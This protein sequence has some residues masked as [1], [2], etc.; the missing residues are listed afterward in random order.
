MSGISINCKVLLS[1]K[2]RNLLSGGNCTVVLTTD[3][4]ING[5]GLGRLSLSSENLEEL[6]ID[7]LKMGET[8]IGIE[9]VDVVDEMPSNKAVANIFSTAVEKED[10]KT[11]TVIKKVAVINPPERGEESTAMKEKTET[12]QE[13]EALNN[14]ECVD[15]VSNLEEFIEEVNKAK[16][17]KTDDID[18]NS[19][20]NDRERAVLMEEIERSESIDKEAYVVNEKVGSLM[21]NDIEVS[22]PLN[23][24]YKLS[25]ISAKR[26]AAS[27]DL[28]G[29]IKS[30]HVKFIAPHEV[31][32]YINKSMSEHGEVV[33]DLKVFDKHQEAEANMENYDD[34][35]NSMSI[36]ESDIGKATEEEGMMLDLTQNMS[37]TK[38]ES[39][40]Q[41][42]KTTKTSVHS[43]K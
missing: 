11:E 10:G 22:L 15:Y 7:I 1:K 36:T 16:R 2:I 26:I 21:V 8:N 9:P 27:R 41:G 4:L 43:R 28:M 25:N 17:K 24:P 19:A 35:D 3:E 38:T 18:L 42:L 32:G 6:P 14:K 29:L 34:D 40:S 31:E 5:K 30:G 23:V 13:F 39:T 33:P 37:T 12:P 20:S